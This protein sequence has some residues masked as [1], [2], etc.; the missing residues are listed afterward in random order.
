[1]EW[2]L[3]SDGSGKSLTQLRCNALEPRVTPAGIEVIDFDHGFTPY[4]MT[5]GPMTV[6][7]DGDLVLTNGPQQQ[8]ANWTK[9]RVDVR[10]FHTSF[11][12]QQGDDNPETYW[13]KG[14]GFTFALASS[15]YPF[16]GTAGGGLGYQGLTDSVA[17]QVR[18]GGQRRRG[19]RTRSGSSPAGP[20]RQARPSAS[21]GPGST[22][23]AATRSGPT[24][25]TTGGP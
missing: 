10:A 6:S 25:P 1:M 8:P 15:N 7:A 11:V 20:P 14:D 24:S 12:F 9:T 5:G 3:N 4:G 21:T 17:D 13:S 18:P 22:C 23:T 16:T 2:P 19:N